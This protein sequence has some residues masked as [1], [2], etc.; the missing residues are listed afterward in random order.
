MVLASRYPEGAL[1]GVIGGRGKTWRH[2][3][4]I[5][6]P[7]QSSLAVELVEDIM[8]VCIVFEVFNGFDIGLF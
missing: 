4:G 1:S 2:L 6:H 8:V 5:L 3:D 7:P